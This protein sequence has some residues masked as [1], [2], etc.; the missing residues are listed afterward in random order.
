MVYANSALGEYNGFYK[1]QSD[2]AFCWFSVAID[3]IEDVIV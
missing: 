2:Y 3:I 1:M